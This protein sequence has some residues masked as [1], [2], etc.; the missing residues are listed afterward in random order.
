MTSNLGSDIIQD[1]SDTEHY[2]SL[3]DRVLTVVGQHFRPEF[4]NRIDDV[5]VFHP[6][7]REHI[8]SIA[9][10]QM[11]ALRQRLTELGYKLE[12]SGA[13]LNK[14]AEIG[15][16]PVYGARPLKRAIKTEIENPL[17]QSLLAGKLKQHIRID[18]CDNGFVTT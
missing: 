5:V 4:I 3:K 8:K 10:I 12:L 13:A 15:F 6:L 14:L 1:V 2:Q 11:L 7:G 16:D 18:Y 9:M 17:A